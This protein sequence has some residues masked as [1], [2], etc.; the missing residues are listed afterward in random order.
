MRKPPLFHNRDG[1]NAYEQKEDDQKD[2][3]S[4]LVLILFCDASMSD[5]RIYTRCSSAI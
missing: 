4:T 3:S 2:D 5:A 1:S